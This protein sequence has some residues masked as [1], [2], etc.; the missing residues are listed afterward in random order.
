MDK[1][2]DDKVEGSR[3]EQDLEGPSVASSQVIYDGTSNAELED[4]QFLSKTIIRKA[5]TTGQK[6]QGRP[7]SYQVE[8][9]RRSGN[10]LA[11]CDRYTYR[12]TRLQINMQD[13]ESFEFDRCPHRNS[14]ISTH[15]SRNR[16]D[17]DAGISKVDEILTIYSPSSQQFSSNGPRSGR[18]NECRTT[19]SLQRPLWCS[20]PAR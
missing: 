10:Y 1:C 6:A 12:A 17:F 7:V 2:G 11:G 20:S 8:R 4:G 18:T 15:I 14:A 3:S 5:S 9:L 13:I 19:H 16:Q